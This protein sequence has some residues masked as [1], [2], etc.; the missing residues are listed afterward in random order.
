MKNHVLIIVLTFIAVIAGI[1]IVNKQ[2]KTVI[3]YT[4][5]KIIVHDSIVVHDTIYKKIAYENISLSKEVIKNA[6]KTDTSVCYSFSQSFPDSTNISSKICSKELPSSKPID[7]SWSLTYKPK[8][9]TVRTITRIDTMNI[10]KKS[11]IKPVHYVIVGV[12]MGIVAR[13]IIRR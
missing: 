13:C 7:L 8:K 2:E 6:E 10:I 1:F 4:E 3:K 9:D 11:K 12:I 5:G